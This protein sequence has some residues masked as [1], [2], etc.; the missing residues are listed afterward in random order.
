MAVRRARNDFIRTESVT[1]DRISLCCFF[2]FSSRRR[3]T[4]Y[5]RD[6]SS[7]VCSSDLQLVR[8][9]PR[10]ISPRFACGRSSAEVHNAW[11][12]PVPPRGGPDPA[13]SVRSTEGPTPVATENL[14]LQTFE[15]APVP[16]S[17]S[18]QHLKVGALGLAGVLF[19]A[20][21]NAATITAMTGN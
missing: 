8:R 5:W 7:D 18:V 21:A 16:R 15:N 13:H 10:A 20:V 2:F 6:W 12:V 1:G 11:C 3:H 17:E 9:F 4:R 19:M 14:P